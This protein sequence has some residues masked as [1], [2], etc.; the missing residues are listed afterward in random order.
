MPHNKK[1]SLI[2]LGVGIGYGILIEVLQGSMHLGRSYEVDD[3]IAN[4]VGAILGENKRI[5]FFLVGLAFALFV[6][7]GAFSYRV[8]DDSVRDLG[9]EVIDEELVVMDNTVQEKKPP[10]PPPPPEIEVV[11]DDEEI[12][13]D[14]PDIED[15]EAEQDDAIEEYEEDEE[16]VEETNEIFEIFDVSK[17][18]EFPG[19]DNGLRKK[20]HVGFTNVGFFVAINYIIELLLL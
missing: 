16:E 14:N 17:K 10:P 7:L 20:A 19:G 15:T 6:V 3:I 13:E 18:A 11:E 2:L 4:T 9:N 1:N 12:E 5:D 8:Y